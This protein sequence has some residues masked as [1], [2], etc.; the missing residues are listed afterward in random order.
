MH[1][2]MILVLLGII[3][4]I[5]IDSILSSLSNLRSFQILYKC[6]LLM[7]K[8]APPAFGSVGVYSIAY[9]SRAIFVG[10]K[11]VFEMR[12]LVIPKSQSLC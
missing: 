9:F 4:S 6:F 8:R 3:T 10:E 5:Q 2:T 11:S 12:D 7:D 1:P